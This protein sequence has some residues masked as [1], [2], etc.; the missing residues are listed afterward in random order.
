M[1]GATWLIMRRE[2]GAYLRSWT[3][4]II[5]ACM[6]ITVGVFF[7]T[8][9]LGGGEKRSAEV[10]WGFF[11][12]LGGVTN[13]ASVFISMRLL[14][15]EKQTGTLVLLTSSPIRD[16]EIILGKFLSAWVFL[17]MI[18]ALTVFMPALVMVN[19]KIAIGQVAAG[20]L[21]VL[22]MGAA[23]LAVGTFGSAIA[24]SQIL[25]VIV[26]ALLLTSLVLMWMLARV[27]EHPLNQ[28]FEF[29]AFWHKHF[30]PFQQG[31]IHVRDIV[32][33][34]AITYFALFCATRVLEARRWR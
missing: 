20:Y 30:P 13:I 14:A 2:L 9:A 8:T 27:T 34:L 10:L 6:L 15:E 22:L 25:A 28:I 7:N 26:S 18:T 24:R 17:A 23:A 19:G 4:Y 16:V 12:Y 1:T 31:T 11:F 21:G 29:L 33:Y 5:A 32:Y 3:G